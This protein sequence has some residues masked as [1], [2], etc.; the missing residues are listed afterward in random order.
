MEFALIA[1]LLLMLVFGIIDFGWMIDRSNVINN[2]ARDAAR[3]A[4]LDGTYSEI[5]QVVTDELHDI[6]VTVPSADVNI[7]ITCTNPAPAANCTGAGDYNAN[8]KSGSAVKVTIA[9]T[10]HWITPVGA[11]CG[12]FG[13]G[14][15]TGNTILLTRTSEMIRE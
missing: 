9:Y 12:F 8:A 10:H 3:S 2:V 13:G 15:C 6:G 14:S 5:N 7:S 4:S 1:P 11:L